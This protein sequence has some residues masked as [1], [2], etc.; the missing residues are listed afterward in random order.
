MFFLTLFLMYY[1]KALYLVMMGLLKAVG[2]TEWYL[3]VSKYK[4]P[5]KYTFHT[6]YFLVNNY[7]TMELFIHL[8]NHVL[9]CVGPSS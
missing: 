8:H 7:K 3:G 5:I 1:T 4:G 6:F 9:P 2:F